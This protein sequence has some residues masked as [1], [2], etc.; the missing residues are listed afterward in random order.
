MLE[1]ESS[2]EIDELEENFKV[3]YE[4]TKVNLLNYLKEIIKFFIRNFFTDL[5]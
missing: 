3:S 1:I 5:E 4:E 2:A